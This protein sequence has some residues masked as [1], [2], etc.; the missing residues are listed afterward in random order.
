VPPVRVPTLAIALLL[1]LIAPCTGHCATLGDPNEDGR[2]SVADGVQTMRAA[3]GLS[4]LCTLETCDVDASGSLTVTDD[5]QVYREAVGLDGTVPSDAAAPR[6]ALSPVNVHF[7]FNATA[8]LQRFQVEVTY[9]FAKGGFAGSAS[10]VACSSNGD[11]FFVVNDRDDGTLALLQANVVPLSFPIDITCHFDQLSGQTLQSSDVGV[12]VV[13]VVEDGAPGDPAQL[14]VDVTVGDPL[15]PTCGTGRIRIG[16]LEG[17]VIDAGWTGIAHGASFPAQS[18]VSFALDCPVGSSTC[19]IAGTAVVDQPAGAPLALSAGGVSVCVLNTFREPVSGTFDCDSGC[20]AANVDLRA[21]VFLAQDSDMPCPPC[22]GDPVPNDGLKGG[23]CG[24]GTTPGGACDA[25]AVNAAFEA[26]GPGFG[27]SSLDCL[28]TGSSVGELAIDLEPLTTGTASS[29]ASVDCL[30]S[31]FPPG[32]CHCPNQV[33]PNACIPDGVC[34]ASGVCEH[35]PIDGIC[36]NHRFHQCRSGTGT[37][38]CDDVFPGAGSCI[39]VPRPCFGDTITR[40]GSCGIDDGTLAGVF[41]VANTR[42]AAVNTTYGL[43]GPAALRLPIRVDPAPTPTATIP[44]DPTFTPSPSPTIVPSPAPTGCTTSP[45]TACHQL[46]LRHQALLVIKNQPKG[47]DELAWRWWGGTATDGLEFGD[48]RWRTHYAL[49][50]YGPAL[51]PPLVFER[52]VSPSHETCPDFSCWRATAR[53]GFA[54]ANR[55]GTED[56]ITHVDLHPGRDGAARVVVQGRRARLTLPNLPLALPLIVQLQANDGSCW[57][58][59]YGSG[60]VDRNDSRR[61]RARAKP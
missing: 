48:P 55:F 4:S 42:A 24:G 18:S 31:A 34:P 44:P 59:T 56:G 32:S 57:E 52:R 5:V 41:C 39:D 47:R 6:A 36:S 20:M 28:P 51:E 53:G 49:C 46:V 12:T 23:T 17:G 25:N 60:D 33:Y 29:T 45:R 1:P 2:I 3:N 50:G 38:D 43:P 22:I 37:E 9:P 7:V 14:L 40:T 19:D 54:Y 8:A 26:A 61:F 21:R 16:T 30:S 10:N 27:T 11:G 35:G 13:E 15:I 58:A